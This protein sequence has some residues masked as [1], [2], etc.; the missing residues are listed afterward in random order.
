MS[1]FYPAAY[2]AAGGKVTCKKGQKDDTT[3][4]LGSLFLSLQSNIAYFYGIPH[5][6]NSDINQ[7]LNLPK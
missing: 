4:L 3:N 6:K 5:T 2:I 7:Q 1:L